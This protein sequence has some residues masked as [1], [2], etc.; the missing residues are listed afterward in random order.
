MPRYE[1]SLLG[2]QPMHVWES[3]GDKPKSFCGIHNPHPVI[4]LAAAEGVKDP[5]MLCPGC[6]VKSAR[7]LKAQQR[8]A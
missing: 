7:L 8:H 6:V 5:N 3:A 1:L 4:S 2:P